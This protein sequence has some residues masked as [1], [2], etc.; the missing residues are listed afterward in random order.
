[1]F[2][3][4]VWKEATNEEKTVFVVLLKNEYLVLELFFDVNN[5]K[6][7]EYRKTVDTDIQVVGIKH[8]AICV[9]SIAEF[10]L[11][12][13]DLITYVDGPHLSWSKDNLFAFV[14]DPDGILFELFENK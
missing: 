14:A 11:Q 7:P 6:L 10:L 1:M 13:K 2:D 9:D 8:F 5:V 3:M 12:K 4:N